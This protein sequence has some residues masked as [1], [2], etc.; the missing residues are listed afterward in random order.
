MTRRFIRETGR[1]GMKL[2]IVGSG[3]IVNDCL[4]AIAELEQVECAALC[5]RSHS[6]DKG[7][8]LLAK[9][10]IPVLYTDYHE[11]LMDEQL[12]FIYIGIVNTQHYAYAK[13]ALE[14]GRNVI[15]EKPFTITA[16]Q[17]AGLAEL[18]KEKGVF[19][20][21]AITTLHF[22]NYDYV[23]ENIKSLGDIKIVQCNFSQYSSRY[24]R[25]LKGDIAPAFDPA[26]SGGA[27]YDLNI[28]NLHFVAGLFGCP[29]EIVYYPNIGHNGVDTSG[30][31]VL[32]Y[33]G[34]IAECVAA[35]D[36]SGPNYGTVQGTKGWIRVNGQTS[37]CESVDVC[38]G[39]EISHINKNTGN[40]RM[41]HEFLAF[42][43]YYAKRDYG[44]CYEILEHTVKVMKLLEAAKD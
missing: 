41:Q 29:E 1:D 17:A 20:W 35:K 9:Y 38:R 13:L 40:H 12:D 2:G 28:Y 14:A 5:V 18:A 36:C 10:G 21:E 33:E 43:R 44:K 11:L 15:L 8:E 25:Y 37:I 23:K 42:E 4:K 3:M 31:L 16:A 7:K 27:L 32:R 26:L 24:D 30:I 19:L 22:P 6:E 39:S 34:F